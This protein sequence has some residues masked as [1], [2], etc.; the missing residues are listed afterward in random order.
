MRVCHPV[1]KRPSKRHGASGQL[2]KLPNKRNK[3]PVQLR[4]LVRRSKDLAADTF[5]RACSLALMRGVRGKRGVAVLGPWLKTVTFDG[6]GDIHTRA[7]FLQS[8]AAKALAVHHVEEMKLQRQ[9]SPQDE[10]V[11]GQGLSD[12]FQTTSRQTRFEHLG[13][14][15]KL[16]GETNMMAR[17][18]MQDQLKA[19]TNNSET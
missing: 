3:A 14:Q 1:A 2:R 4:S 18:Q 12:N 8:L 6:C 5:S 9:G 16:L 7:E 15:F 11:D 17:A 10:F 19:Q 13:K